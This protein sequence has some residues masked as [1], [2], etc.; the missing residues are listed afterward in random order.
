MHIGN[1]PAASTK[2]SVQMERPMDTQLL[3]F[4]KGNMVILAF[5][6]SQP[7]NF[8]DWFNNFSLATSK[9]G[10]SFAAMGD[11]TGSELSGHECRR[12]AFL[13]WLHDLIDRPAKGQ[14]MLLLGL[15]EASM[16]ATKRCKHQ[17]LAACRATDGSHLKYSTHG[18]PVVLR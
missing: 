17:V 12:D 18:V 8:F 6:G 10:A 16:A 2:A 1:V 9:T 14:G 4:T 7:V 13:K 11:I 3:L 5:R 15:H